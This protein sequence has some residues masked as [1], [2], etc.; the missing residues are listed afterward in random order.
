[1]LFNLIDDMRNKTTNP[2][3]IGTCLVLL[4]ILFIRINYGLDLTDEM[5]YYGEIKGLIDTGTLFSNDLFFQQ[6]VYILFFPFFY[7]YHLLFGFEGLVFF[8]RLLMSMLSILVFLYA[9]QKL[10]KLK[11]SVTVASL[12]ALALTFAIPIGGVFAPSYNTIS[13]FFWI[14]FTLR[15]YEWK[16]STAFSW[17]L[18]P[19]IT[20]FAHPTSAVMMA[21]LIFVRLWVEREFK[22]IIELFLVFLGG[23]FIVT[24][25]F[26][27]F[28]TPQEYL[29]SITFSSGYSVGT[30]FFSN[31]SEQLRLA[32][33]YIIFLVTYVAFGN[34]WLFQRVF[35]K[36][37]FIWFT[38]L[39]IGIAIILFSMGTEGSFGY[40]TPMVVNFL[41][42]LSVLAYGW[43]LSNTPEE[44]INFKVQINWL[45]VLLLGY[46]TTIGVTSGNG[47]AQSTFAF[48]VVLPLLLGIAVNSAPNK[49]KTDNFLKL[50]CPILLVILYAVHWSFNPY[51]ENVWWKA[52]QP[53]QFVPEFRFINT[54]Q[55]R[56]EFIQR[57][58]YE[59][60]SK[61]QG[62]RALIISY[63]PG[64]YLALD[65]HPETCMLFM[66]SLTSDKSEKALIDCLH[67]KQPEVV[68]NIFTNN[69]I[70]EENSRIKNVMRNY[71]SQLGFVCTIKIIGFTFKDNF[72][73]LQLK[74]LLCN[75]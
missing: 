9:Y 58:K 49:K 75:R 34:F 31:R 71:Y 64:L 27:Y 33:I 74:Y 48:Q 18:I 2:I 5:Q 13:Q 29:S 36:L 47:I 10:L 41:S 15:F 4:F 39:T 65:T 54:S 14:V 57:M 11:F 63:F 66:H 69:N 60:Q 44:N 6:S 59:L 12:T 42:G 73:P 8:S 1:M 62:K 70:V 61:V 28:A 3:F 20:V 19:I 56:V 38:N 7:L 43:S 30:R 25:I 68:V 22:R 45:I 46:A 16:K 35:N 21:L 50:L 40:F 51:Q 24:L 23:A 55:D 37:N 72:N 26:L 52:T 53:I 67:K 17:G 32:I